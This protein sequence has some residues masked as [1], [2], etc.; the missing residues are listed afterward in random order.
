MQYGSSL[1]WQEV[2]FRVTGQN[3]LDGTAV[4]DFFKPLEDWLRNENLRTQEYPGWIYGKPYLANN[5]IS[6]KLKLVFFFR[7]R[8]L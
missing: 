3:K 2:L 7:R 5:L 6:F 8:L 1:P 4:R